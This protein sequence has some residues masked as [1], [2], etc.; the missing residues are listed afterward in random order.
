M[1]KY[2]T[3]KLYPLQDKFLEFFNRHSSNQFYLT[4]GT[5]LS[6]FY[7]HHRYSDD[8]DFFSQEELDD[9]RSVGIVILDEAKRHGFSIEVETISDNFLRIF[10]NEDKTS[11]KIDLV[12]DMTFHWG[13]FT[14]FPLCQ[15]VDNVQ[16]ILAN[17]LTCISRYEVKDIAD[18]WIMAKQLSFSWREIMDMADKKSPVDPVEISKI[19]KLLPQDELKLVKWAFNTNLDEVFSEL[20]VIAEDILLGQINSLGSRGKPKNEEKSN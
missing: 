7:F 16:N 14:N 18:I 19:I 2:Y 10:V 8:L 17:K 20:Q 1:H 5:A 15:N 13:K 12:N 9:F 6:R 11:L 4:G 3:E